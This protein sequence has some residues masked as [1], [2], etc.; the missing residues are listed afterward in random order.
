MFSIEG[1]VANTGERSRVEITNGLIEKVCQPTGMADVVLK[2]ELIFP[3]FVDLHVHAREDTTHRDDYKEDFITAGEAAVNGGVVAFAEM[4]NN[5]MP[6]VDDASYEV[7]KELTQKCIVTVL[8]YALIEEGT[9]ALSKKVPYKAVLG[10]GFANHRF[11]SAYEDLDAG[12]AYYRGEF[13]SF[14]CEDPK[15]LTEYAHHHMHEDQRPHVSE[16][17]AVD[18]V[19]PLIKKHGLHGKI[20]HCSTM[21]GVEMVLGAKQE[22]VDVT[23]EV[24]PHHLYFDTSMLTEETRKMMQVNPPIRH[25]KENR[26]ALI[27]ALRRGDIDYL[28]T[29]HAPHS[30]EDKEKGI[31][32]MPELDTYGPFV[33]W[34]I[35]EHNFS[36]QQ[37]I[38]VCS[39]NPGRFMGEFLDEKYGEIEGGYVGSFTIIDMNRPTKITKNILKTKCGWSPF[40]GVTFPGSV[41]MTIVKGKILKNEIQ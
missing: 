10:T 37:V 2:D 27:D 6:P 8:P 41:V 24:S 33:T 21:R 34:L 11:F 17:T 29:D 12:L 20:C 4:P 39:Y 16:T 1:I 32:G 31:S 25:T 7:K 14:H 22:G 23:I 13:V 26:L 19:L 38:R 36:S 15:I 40:E 35:K 30:V 18:V 9:K 5:P 28:A 3:G